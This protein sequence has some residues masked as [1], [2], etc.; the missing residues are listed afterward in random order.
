MLPTLQLHL[1]PMLPT[2]HLH[3]LRYATYTTPLLLPHA[4]YTTPP[5]APNATY[6]LLCSLMLLNTE[7]LLLCYPY[8]LHCMPVLPLLHAT[9]TAHL[10]APLLLMSHHPILLPYA[11]YSV[12]RVLCQCQE[13][14]ANAKGQGVT[15]VTTHCSGWN[16][17]RGVIVVRWMEGNLYFLFHWPMYSCGSFE[18]ILFM[19][20]KTLS[21]CLFLKC[22]AMQ[23]SDI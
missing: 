5:S 12:T 7:L 23:S 22:P 21:T 14:T 18:W 1:L 6:I 2:L 19:L 11:A 15:Q 4:T 16:A 20:L 17:Q 3:L 13:Q 9:Y 8:C 10:P